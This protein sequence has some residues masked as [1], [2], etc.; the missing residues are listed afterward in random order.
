MI[1]ATRMFGGLQQADIDELFHYAIR[2]TNKSRRISG[3]HEPDKS[4]IPWGLFSKEG[5]FYAFLI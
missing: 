2:Y 1:R 4:N 3:G 5:T